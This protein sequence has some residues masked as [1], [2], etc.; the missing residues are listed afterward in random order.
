MVSYTSLAVTGYFFSPAPSLVS[1][2]RTAEKF[3]TCLSLQSRKDYNF[4]PHQESQD[5]SHLM[6]Y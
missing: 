5:A 4:K 2:R 1:C 3:P 6:V